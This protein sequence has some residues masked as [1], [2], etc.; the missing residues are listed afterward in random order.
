M[1]CRSQLAG[2][3]LV[4]GIG[5]ATF[6]WAGNQTQLAAATDPELASQRLLEQY[7]LEA[8][9][10]LWQEIEARVGTPSPVATLA[11][12]VIA[13]ESG[14]L[15][16]AHAFLETA[17]TEDGGSPY[18]HY[19]LG[20]LALEE[21]R[22][23]DALGHLREAVRRRRDFAAAYRLI[24]HAHLA[25]GSP[26]LAFSAYRT[27]IALAP[28][29]ADT[30]LE[31]G[32]AYLKNGKPEHAAVAFDRAYELNNGLVEALFHLAYARLNSGEVDQGFA[33]LERY[34]AA[35]SELEA[36]QER[37]QRAKSLLARYAGPI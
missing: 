6:S 26:E 34:V 22:A 10:A 15:N 31:L 2:L 19:Y 1:R 33:A 7:T 25:L 32:T 35:A 4:I 24:G 12:G 18:A 28:G 30:H 27:V 14:N 36:E 29:H 23:A 8:P 9:L 17:C 13:L 11:R 37:V 3:V 16:E 5:S 21:G 20:R